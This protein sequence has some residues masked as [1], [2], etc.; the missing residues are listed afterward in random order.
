MAVNLSASESDTRLLEI[1]KLERLGVVAHPS[2]SP[3]RV[4]TRTIQLRNRE[5]EKEQG[6]WR[7][8]LVAMLGVLALETVWSRW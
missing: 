5:L 3:E 7:W 6:L 4:A 2:E 8:F 1:E